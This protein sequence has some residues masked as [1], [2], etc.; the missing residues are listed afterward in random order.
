MVHHCFRVLLLSSSAP[1]LF[2]E[3]L[4]PPPIILISLD[5]HSLAKC[6]VY[7]HQAVLKTN[8]TFYEL[9]DDAVEPFTSFSKTLRFFLQSS[10]LEDCTPGDTPA[11]ESLIDSDVLWNCHSFMKPSEL[12]TEKSFKLYAS[13][14]IL[15]HIIGF[16]ISTKSRFNGTPSSLLHQSSYEILQGDLLG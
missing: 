3:F 15:M 9:E 1:S 11:P 4:L 13:K 8:A 7:I 10:K 16:V 6:P 14:F 5:L 12:D 2:P